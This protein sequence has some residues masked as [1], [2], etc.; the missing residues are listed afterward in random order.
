[1]KRNLLTLLLVLVGASCVAKVQSE[2]KSP[3][4]HGHSSSGLK[5]SAADFNLVL[6][7]AAPDDPLVSTGP[8]RW[9]G[10][11]AY[12]FD[13][14]RKGFEQAGIP[15]YLVVREVKAN[16]DIAAVKAHFY[17]VEKSAGQRQDIKSGVIFDP[18]F[19]PDGKHVLFKFG[20]PDTYGSYQLHVLDTTSNTVRL[21]SQ[22]KLIYRKTIWSPDSKYIAYVSGGD[23]QGRTIQGE[24]Y[25]GPLRLYICHWKT[26]KESL[27]TENDTVRGSF[28]WAAPHT[29]LY[30]AL[31]ESEQEVMEKL[32]QQSDAVKNQQPIKQQAGVNP[33]PSI[34]EYSVEQDKSQ[35]LIRDGYRPIPSADGQWIAFF[36]SEQ[37]DKPYPLVRSWMERPGDAVLT[38]AEREG[39]ERKALTL[40][41]GLYPYVVWAPDGRHLLTIQDIEDGV[42]NG[43]AKVTEWD[44]QTGKLRVVT[45]LQEKNFGRAISDFKPLTFSSNGATLFFTAFELIGR[46]IEET[47]GTFM[48]ERNSL[49]A[50]DV[51]TG[52]ISPIAQF[53]RNWGIDWFTSPAPKAA[54]SGVAK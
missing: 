14:L 51:P 22:R 39:R 8:S 50:I 12:S 19:A 7:D 41:S 16:E 24:W 25:L 10:H 5:D 29:L 31:S 54:N 44:A 48:T 4:S 49:H 28:A 27:V 3:P 34:Y 47:R 11:L 32:P 17:T 40:E 13:V 18:Q 9:S 37:P 15:S 43:Q 30:A 53:K 38:V 21:V 26:G 2:P 20:S 23:A 46:R 35:L 33:R 45:I 42:V 36:G 52:N 6:S 1:M